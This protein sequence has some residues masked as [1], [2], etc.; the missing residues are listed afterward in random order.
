MVV[1][2]KRE[3]AWRMVPS[4][5]KVAVRSTFWLRKEDRRAPFEEVVASHGVV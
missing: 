2:L 3:E 5:P 1:V 4:P